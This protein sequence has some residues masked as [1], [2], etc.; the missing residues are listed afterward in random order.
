MAIKPV[1]LFEHEST[2][3]NGPVDATPTPDA[4]KDV[5]PLSMPQA[6]SSD[7]SPT[8]TAVPVEDY[9]PV[10]P[11]S[12]LTRLLRL[13]RYQKRR[14][15]QAEENLHHLH[16]AAART[17]RLARAARTVQHTLAECIRA[18]DKASFANLLHAFRDACDDCLRPPASE[19]DAGIASEGRRTTSVLDNLSSASRA[20]VLDFLSKIRNDGNFIADRLKLLTHKELIALLPDRSTPRSHDSIFA[21]STRSLSR[22]SKP[23]GYAVDAQVD[24]LSSNAYNS[25]LEALIFS[26]HGLSKA[27]NVE[28]DRATDIWAVVSA[29]L[30]SE[31]KPGSERLVPAVLDIWTHLLPWPG[32][33]RLQVWIL[34]TLQQGA[35]LLD[36]PSKQSFKA[37]VEGRPNISPEDEQRTDSFYAQA[38]ESL[39][40]LFADQNGATVIPPGALKMCHAIWTQLSDSPRHQGVLPQF[41][42]TRWLFSTFVMDAVTLPEVSSLPFVQ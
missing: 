26:T 14:C 30:I 22:V 7:P 13:Q 19:A 42:M 34:Q 1:F 28:L 40:D 29:N 2:I 41:L 10:V 21:G 12:E 38:A 23:L 16:I 11:L 27:G 39:L 33:D 6:H 24:L 8:R 9:K 17:S 20:S 37:R 35:F 3:R 18:E 4:G 15:Y 31:Q 32:K 5:L 36:Q 25:P